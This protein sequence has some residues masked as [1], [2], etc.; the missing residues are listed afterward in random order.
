LL[1]ARQE[2]NRQSSALVQTGI[3]R[4]S[5]IPLFYTIANVLFERSDTS[6]D[7]AAKSLSDIMQKRFKSSEI[8]QS[9]ETVDAF[10]N[11]DASKAEDG[12]GA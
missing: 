5:K 12:L 2:K 6:S 3:I 4:Y 1:L 11:Q 9:Q 10:L 8:K 7:K